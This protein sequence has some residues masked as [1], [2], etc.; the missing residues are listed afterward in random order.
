MQTRPTRRRIALFAA[1]CVGIAMAAGIGFSAIPGNSGVI[2]ACYDKNG[3]LRVIDADAGQTCDRRE[4]ALNWN[5]T[6]PRG[7]SDAFVGKI[8]PL[9]PLLDNQTTS[10]FTMDV[11]AGTYV[12]Q[13]FL[14]LHPQTLEG[15]TTASCELY[16]GSHQLDIFLFQFPSDEDFMSQSE[17]LVG[18][19]DLAGPTTLE[20][21]CRANYTHEFSIVGVE[22]GSVVA[23]AV[24]ALTVAQ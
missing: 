15:F 19:D 1:V 21:F 22:G 24:G 18:W 17:V 9:D 16:A 2:S 23:T 5:Q 12:I 6:G 8:S 4:T 11:P 14:R 3:A 20:L 10:I 13:A 7:P